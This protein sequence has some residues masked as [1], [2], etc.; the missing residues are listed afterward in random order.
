M[1]II[2]DRSRLFPQ[3]LRYFS[4]KWP[5]NISQ[6][7]LQNFF[8]LCL[9]F[10]HIKVGRDMCSNKGKNGQLCIFGLCSYFSK[11]FVSSLRSLYRISQ[12][13]FEGL[14][15]KDLWKLSS[16]SL[17][18][19]TNQLYE[20]FKL[21]WSFSP[22]LWAWFMLNLQEMVRIPF[23]SACPVFY[24]Y[25]WSQEFSAGIFKEKFS[26][27]AKLFICKYFERTGPFYLV[28]VMIMLHF[29]NGSSI[30]C[31]IILDCIYFS[32]WLR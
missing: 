12:K 14:W 10:S 5:Q 17:P 1:Q 25:D 16:I 6:N 31:S 22:R 20:L 23:A 29:T 11:I 13:W 7:I 30:F 32:L 18:V 3:V 9:Y 19:Q 15:L 28:F 26:D 27:L 8:L 24:L 2:S 21:L 4:R